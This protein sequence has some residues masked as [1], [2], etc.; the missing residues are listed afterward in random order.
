M[1]LAP[2][3]L[4]L[5]KYMDCVT[6]YVVYSNLFTNHTIVLLCNAINIVQGFCIYN[7]KNM[8]LAVHK[9]NTSSCLVHA[10]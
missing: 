2:V 4:F 6:K 5:S 10:I 8:I 9:S 1:K 7:L 3:K